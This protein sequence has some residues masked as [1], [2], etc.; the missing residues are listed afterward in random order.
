M[1]NNTCGGEQNVYDGGMMCTF[2]FSPIDIQ[3][4]LVVYASVFYMSL[5]KE[6][7]KQHLRRRS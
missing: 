6:Y 5:P 1:L 4:S 2:W 3:V 7:E